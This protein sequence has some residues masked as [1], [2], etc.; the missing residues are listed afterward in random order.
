MA[1]EAGTSVGSTGGSEGSSSQNEQLSVGDQARARIAAQDKAA[2]PSQNQQKPSEK[3]PSPPKPSEESSVKDAMKKAAEKKLR[4]YKVYGEEVEI[5]E[6]RLDEYAQKGIAF[7]KRG[8]KL[9]EME[10]KFVS[11]N[12]AIEKGDKAAVKK[13]LGDER[14]HKFAVEHI[15]EL[16]EEEEMTPQERAY[17]AKE[18]E[19]QSYKAQLKAI[20]DKKEADEKK[21]LDEHYI[22]E[23]DEEFAKAFE[24]TNLPKHPRVMSRMVSLMTQNIK[25][26]LKLPAN[27]IAGLVR[28][29]IT[30]EVKSLLGALEG[31]ALAEVLGEEVSQRIRQHGL[32]QFR[33]PLAGNRVQAPVK[34]N[35]EQPKERQLFG[36]ME[37]TRPTKETWRERLAKIKQEG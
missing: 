1:D 8:G 3:D 28:K 20:Q 22:K 24:E 15:N 6:E 21:A 16:L 36:K 37:D 9:A 18:A 35:S 27:K 11:L 17:K 14:F 34:Q 26:G 7:E 10:R 32:S 4:K 30:G 13:I 25:M 12:E 31:P 19:L 33:D 29:E 5:D 2:K 23:F